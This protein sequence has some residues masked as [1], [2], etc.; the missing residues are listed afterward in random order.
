MSGYLPVTNVTFF[1][2]ALTIISG[3]F[4][5]ATA[6][7]GVKTYNECKEIQGV[8]KWDNLKMLLTHTMTMS[9]MIPVVLIAQLFAGG[10]VAAAMAIIYG[11]MG[12]VGNA[13]AFAMTKEGACGEVTKKDSKNYLIFG[14]TASSFIIL[15]GSAYLVM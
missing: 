2:I 11:I 8:K 10:K 9:M 14:M 6:S 7:I 15:G 3:I 1:A 12:L 5:I 4:Y 13:T